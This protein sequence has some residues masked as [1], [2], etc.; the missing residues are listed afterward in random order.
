VTIHSDNGTG[1]PSGAP[2]PLHQSCDQAAD[3]LFRSLHSNV[4]QFV[5]DQR[6]RAA[7]NTHEPFAG[8]LTEHAAALDEIRDV[9][10]EALARDGDLFCIRK[11][12][13]LLRSEARYVRE[14]A[15]EET[16][17]A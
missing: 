5:Y 9:L 7:A 12:L 15:G 14:L 11:A 8:I 16:P 10:L 2:N 1:A 13:N 6:L 17:H 4:S 3:A